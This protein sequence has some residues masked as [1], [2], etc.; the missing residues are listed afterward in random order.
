MI[1]H[2]EQDKNGF[3]FTLQI[4]EKDMTFYCS[5]D[6][7]REEWMKA[8]ST[9]CLLEMVSTDNNYSHERMEKFDLIYVL[10]V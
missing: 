6:I 8:I 2:Q 10:I 9:F 4:E 3:P 1:D 5:D 7:T